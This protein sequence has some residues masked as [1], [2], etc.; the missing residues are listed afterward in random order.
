M[1]T[2]RSRKRTRDAMPRR[3]E[4]TL[5]KGRDLLKAAKCLDG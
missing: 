2:W 3:I 1:A 5:K 4:E